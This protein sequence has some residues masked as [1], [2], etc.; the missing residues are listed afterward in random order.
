MVLKKEKAIRVVNTLR[1]DFKILTGQR[2]QSALAQE[3]ALNLI[4]EF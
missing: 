1:K 4:E 2:E 3:E